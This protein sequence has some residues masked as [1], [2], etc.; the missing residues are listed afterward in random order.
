MH[1]RR[2]A[3]WVE[4]SPIAFCLC[5]AAADSPFGES[6]VPSV[7]VANAGHGTFGN[8]STQG[9]MSMFEAEDFAPVAIH[10]RSRV[11]HAPDGVT[12]VRQP[13]QM[14]DAG[15]KQ[16]GAG[17]MVTLAQERW[18][19]TARRRLSVPYGRGTGMPMRSP[20]RSWR[21]RTSKAGGRRS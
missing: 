4:A 15:A 5:D 10:R 2:G 21:G 1:K 16:G 18:D 3:V 9:T 7:G 12:A 8:V 19:A 6:V 17:D 20:R 14:T 13:R 11:G